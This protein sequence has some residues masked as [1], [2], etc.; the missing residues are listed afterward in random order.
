MPPTQ[1]RR[2]NWRRGAQA[3]MACSTIPP[4]K[5]SARNALIA[6]SRAVAS[7]PG[8]VGCLSAA[9]CCSALDS[10]AVG[11]AAAGSAGVAPAFL[12]AR[13]A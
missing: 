5:F 8:A 9:C 2:A 4:S 11:S 12:A 1:R 3:F 10:A 6:D 13:F 7:D